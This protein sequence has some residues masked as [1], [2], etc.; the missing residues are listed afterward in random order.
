[1]NGNQLKTLIVDSNEQDFS[2]T[3]QMLDNLKAWQ[4]NPE[5]ESTYEAA[6][7]KI[8][9]ATYDV[10]LL[11]CHNGHDDGL[12]FLREATKN[13]N[14]TSLILLVDSEDDPLT[15]EA[16][17]AGAVDY[18]VKDKIDSQLLERAFR[19]AIKHKQLAESLQDRLKQQTAQL[20]TI[21]NSLQTKVQHLEESETK[22]RKREEQYKTFFNLDVYGVEVLDTAGAIVNC[23]T[24]YES[25][26]GYS[27]QEVVGRHT[28]D[29]VSDRSKALFQKKLATL[30]KRGYTESEVELIRKDGTILTLWKRYRAIYDDS[31]VWTGIV[32]FNRDITERMKAVKQISSLARALEQSP[33]AV[34]I[35]DEA[36]NVEYV[37]FRYTEITGRD[38][39]EMMSQNLHTIQAES[40]S[41]DEYGE[42]WQAVSNGEEWQAELRA[43][44]K[45]G[46]LYWESVM[47]TPMFDNKG[48]ITNF[49]VVKDD[50]THRKESEAQDIQSQQRVGDLV[51]EHISDLTAANEK[52]QQEIA[53]RKRIETTLRRS[54][55]RLKAQYKGIPMPTYSWQKAGDNFI[56]VDYNDAAERDSQGRIA[57]FMGKTVNQIFAG[58]KE[59][60]ADFERC[61]QRKTMVKREAPYQLVTTGENKHFVTTYN[62]V[63]PNLV[64]VHIEDITKYKHIEAELKEHQ[65]QL[66]SLTQQQ[67]A[68]LAEAREAL[69]HDH[70]DH[71][72][73]EEQL[74]E[75]AAELQHELVEHHHAE[76]ELHDAEARLKEISLNIDERLREQYRT[77]PIPAYTYQ[78][79]GGE[80]ILIDFNDAAAE[81]MGRIVDFLGK[82]VSETFKE[83]P[84][85]L[86]D[87]ARCYHEKGIV[88]REAPY[89]LVTTGEYKYFRTSYNYLPP[90]LVI[91]HIEDITEHK[92]MEVELKEYRG[93]FEATAAAHK[94]E[95][96]KRNEAV[97]REIHKRKLMENS[98][99]Q[100]RTELNEL[101]HKLDHIVDEIA[102]KYNAEI[103]QL[104]QT[105][106]QE[107][108]KRQ[109]ADQTRQ[110]LENKISQHQGDLE[111]QV[112]E[113]TAELIKTNEQL[114]REIVEHKR[115]EAS[116]REARTR[117]KA[118]YK[119]IPVPTYS[120]QRVSD[121]FILVDYNNA[122]EQSSQGT[123][124][125]LMGKS[126]NDVFKD[127]TQVKEDFTKCFTEKRT[128][129]RE[130]PYKLLRTGE[131]KFFVT[132]YNFVPPNLIIVYIQDITDKKQVERALQE[133]ETQVE[134][135]CRYSPDLKLTFVNNVY[136]WYFNKHRADLIGLE[137][138]FVH[139][140]DVERVKTH[141]SSLSPKNPAGAIEYRVEKANGNVYWQQ[142]ITQATFDNQ[143]HLVEIQSVGR[144]ITKRKK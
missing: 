56:L 72:H 8:K 99:N 51:S 1:M 42:M 26:L 79:I 123:I 115:S 81:A 96:A 105:L 93:Q 17:N 141:F 112:Q 44:R 114:Q 113:R 35:T 12:S 21:N 34:M 66:E 143:G 95:L 50:I 135:M 20:A 29:F 94:A 7:A 101:K 15:I 144:D 116:L 60:L 40:L 131:T 92:Q 75:A 120:W 130:A 18:L 68:E 84:Q 22:L 109:Q 119:A 43:H 122:A 16:L 138:P 67:A 64:V 10:C 90:N 83:R 69:K 27:H 100:T 13:G 70:A 4:I 6:L 23:N 139:K 32:A 63:P 28:T 121:D 134:L 5:W 107:I 97:R 30:E 14:P 87:F 3:R 58:K 48:K 125:D 49:I 89:Q 104:K 41:E 108:T 98:L 53:D 19:Y 52:L 118:Q 71:E 137:L 78:V 124:A 117:L 77:I 140:D 45:G 80:F 133:S 126:V 91:V 103:T 61:F 24:T 106:Q 55:T 110:N 37:N 142:W 31:G 54:R 136:C 62:F 39:D 47:I 85:V 57:D 86:E 76:D 65:E 82:P 88:R 11:N 59:I 36:G 2:A 128:I 111:R 25:M 73:A 127:R 74:K 38:Y 129:K 102:A 46:E 33:V 132:T 9:A